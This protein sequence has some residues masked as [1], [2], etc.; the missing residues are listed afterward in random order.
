VEEHSGWVEA[1][2]NEGGGATFTVHL[3]LADNA[4]AASAIPSE[5]EEAV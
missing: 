3:Q 4:I 5:N 1:A 2:N